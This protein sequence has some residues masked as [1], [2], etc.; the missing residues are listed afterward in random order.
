MVGDP[1]HPQEPFGVSL[2]DRRGQ[3]LLITWTILFFSQQSCGVWHYGKLD[4]RKPKGKPEQTGHAQFLNQDTRREVSYR[5]ACSPGDIIDADH[6]RQRRAR[7]LTDQRFQRRPDKTNPH[8]PQTKHHD[9]RRWG[10]EYHAQGKRQN[11][12]AAAH[13]KHPC[14]L[15]TSDAADE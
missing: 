3:V 12:A 7:P 4:R 14:L 13:V 9:L 2:A 10:S 11:D 8:C 5:A 15:Y 1:G 6:L